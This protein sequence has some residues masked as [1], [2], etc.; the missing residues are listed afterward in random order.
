MLYPVA[1]TSRVGKLHSALTVLGL[2]QVL[3]SIDAYMLRRVA[4]HRGQGLT[5]R[6]TP[7]FLLLFA[8]GW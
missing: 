2:G 7:L 8:Q 4:K 5:L 1:F 6:C 3:I